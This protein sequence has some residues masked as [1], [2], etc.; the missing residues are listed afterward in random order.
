MDIYAKHRNRRVGL[1][2]GRE[3]E[4]L[5][6]IRALSGQCRENVLMLEEEL[7]SHDPDW[8]ER[9]GLLDDRYEVYA[10]RIPECRQAR[11]ALSI[12]LGRGGRQAV[13]LHGAVPARAA[14]RRARLLVTEH[15]HLRNPVWE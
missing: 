11:L 1:P 14:C 15:R 13:M 10:A 12:D 9:C 7:R 2:E 8:S 3:A 4:V 5:D 6:T